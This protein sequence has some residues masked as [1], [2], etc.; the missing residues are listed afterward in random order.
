MSSQRKPKMDERELAAFMEREFPQ[1]DPGRLLIEEVR[2]N[3]ARVRRTVDQSH[4]RPGGTVSG[5]TLMAL[6]DSSMYV[7][8]LA[9]IGPVALV[10]T[11]S[12][13]INF[14]RKPGAVDIVAETRLHKLGRKLAVGE[15]TI[16]SDGCPDAVAVATVTYSI[17]PDLGVAP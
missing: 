10:V 7:A 15:V 2:A 3:Y 11:T 14:L 9:M 4:L 13:S 17:P 5:P 12:L 16:F 8:L 1:S 6:A